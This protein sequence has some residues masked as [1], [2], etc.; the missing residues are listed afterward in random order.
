[1]HDDYLWNPEGAAEADPAVAALE[2]TL[3]PLR[4]DPQP[5]RLPPPEPEP[6]SAPARRGWSLALPLGAA[7][8]AAS[9]VLMLRPQ[10]PP[11]VVVTVLTKPSVPVVA[12]AEAPPTP[13]ASVEAQPE[14]QPEVPPAPPSSK[15]PRVKRPK[16][17]TKP[18][19][20]GRSVDCILDPT[21][22][23]EPGAPRRAAEPDDA[24][25]VDCILD[26][27]KC[28]RAADSHLPQTLSAAQVREAVAV[29]KP[30][31]QACGPKHH[32]AVGTRVK[33]KLSVSGKT[34]RVLSAHA[35]DPWDG[36]PL[37]GCVAKALSKARFPRFQK[38]QLGVVYPITVDGS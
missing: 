22:C 12:A 24:V 8:L 16:P 21:R 31:A 35:Q 6:A 5:L 28:G 4:Y 30:T 33:V 23:E 27:T 26:R 7:A 32:A 2:R 19:P 15:P 29:V 20:P 13:V 11:S 18:D 17:R 10:E 37:G 25:K 3:A 36:K 9:L 38:D 14:S 1:M 34:G